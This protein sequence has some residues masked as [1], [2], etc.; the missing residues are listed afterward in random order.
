MRAS[1]PLS[2]VYFALSALAAPFAK[3]FETS[4]F[5][6]KD[7]I[8]RDFVIVG[9]GAAGSY[10]AVALK[11]QHKSFIVI[12]KTNRLGG[13]TATYED[14]ITGGTV[15]YG[16]QIYDND[17]IVRNFFS[18][19]NTPLVDFS[20]ANF[21]K[22]IYADFKAGSLLNLTTGSLGQGYLDELAKY[23]YLNDGIVL[24]DP[25]PEDL[26][27]PWVDYVAKHNL[28]D[29][30]MATL[31]R[32]AIPGKL[33]N[34]PALYVFNDLNNLMLHEQT[35]GAV[36]NGKRDNSQLY[37]NA[38][39]E[40]KDDVLLNSTVISGDRDVSRH[41]GVRLIIQT[42]MGQKLIVARQ[43]VIA[44]PQTIEN[45]KPFGL[46]ERER[47]ILSQVYG[48]PYYGG[49]VSNTGLVGGFSY[50]NYAAKTTYNVADIPSVVGFN[51]SPVDGL[52]YYWYNSVKPVSQKRIESDARKAIKLLQKLTHTVTQPE[53]NFLAFRD[54]GPFH[55]GA[56]V[57][58]IRDGF[59]REMY[60]LQGHRNTWYIGTLF[61]PGSSQV[62]NNTAVMLPDILAAAK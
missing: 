28:Q 13:H 23:P 30:A 39:R 49:V 56:E 7:V 62:W 57:D 21:G 31:A 27:L 18:R 1:S 61:V 53:P 12:E 8:T 10:A 60:A 32:P 14:P 43:L 22:P 42:P 38:L 6:A 51:P 5:A 35:G 36:V 29:S 52:L 2:I 11:D 48:L 16:V 26:L 44:I 58:D 19:L 40:L 46:D 59:Y 17:T 33:L 3:K 20:F 41:Q 34:I 25:V 9:G 55:L 47:R 4:S 37:R 15:D 24:P 54:F 50:K 45:M